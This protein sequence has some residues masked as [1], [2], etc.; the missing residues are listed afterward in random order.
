MSHYG[1]HATWSVDHIHKDTT[2]WWKTVAVAWANKGTDNTKRLCVE[3]IEMSFRELLLINLLFLSDLHMSQSGSHATW[4]V[5]LIHKDTAGGQKTVGCL[6]KQVG[7]KNESLNCKEF[8]WLLYFQRFYYRSSSSWNINH[9]QKYI[10][11]QWD[12]GSFNGK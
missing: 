3:W 1:S 5:N 7:W 2:G 8:H 4:S 12:M 10:A 6:G 9:I 11:G